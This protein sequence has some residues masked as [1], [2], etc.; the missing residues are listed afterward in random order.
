MEGFGIILDNREVNLY[1]FFCLV[2]TSVGRKKCN[3]D[4]HPGHSAPEYWEVRSNPATLFYGKSSA[5]RISADIFML[6]TSDFSFLF[7]L[8]SHCSEF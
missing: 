7:L 4:V 5:L 6:V 1:S 8:N 3:A 2:V